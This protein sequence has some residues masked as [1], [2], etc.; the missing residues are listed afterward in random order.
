MGCLCGWFLVGWYNIVLWC[1]CYLIAGR[2]WISRCC[3]SF[4]IVVGIFGCAV[5][6]CG[7][8]WVRFVGVITDCTPVGLGFGYA[9][10]V[11]LRAVV[12]VV[13]WDL[14]AVFALC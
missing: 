4:R 14:V 6:V 3:S 7:F 9:G 5:W 2:C 11:C 13:L 8:L 10:A 12:A 1:E